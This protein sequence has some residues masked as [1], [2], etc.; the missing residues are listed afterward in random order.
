M[1]VAECLALAFERFL[2][3]RDTFAAFI[4]M[5]AV[6]EQEHTVALTVDQLVDVLGLGAFRGKF[7]SEL[8][9]GSRRIVDL[10]MSLAHRPKVLILDEPSSG[11]AQRETEALGPLL[12]RVQRELDCSLIVIEHDMPLLLGISH[13]LL[14]LETGRLIAEGPPAEVVRNPAVVASYL[15]TDESVIARSGRPERRRKTAARVG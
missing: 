9:T 4:G 10:G 8:S 13:R 15:D 2:D 6:R 1:T 5:P 12:E 11:I 3:V 14:A 7:I